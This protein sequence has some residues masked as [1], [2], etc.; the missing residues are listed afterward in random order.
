MSVRA[1]KTPAKKKSLCLC[2]FFDSLQL[3]SR[4]ETDSFSGRNVDLFASARIAADA[5]LPRFY[6]EHTEAP[7]FDA[8]AAA[9]RVFQGLEDGFDGLLRLRPA[10]IRR[11][12][13]GIYD[14]ELNHVRLQRLGR[15]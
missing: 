10:D 2:G 3:F 9:K 4:L 7:E 8:L 13:D 12:Y 11:R 14:V 1:A 15:C 6:A 5:G